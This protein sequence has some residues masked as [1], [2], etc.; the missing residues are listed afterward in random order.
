MVIELEK[1]D[2]QSAHP[3]PVYKIFFVMSLVFL[4]F[5][6]LLTILSI[7]RNSFLKENYS[8]LLSDGTFG[9]ATLSEYHP[10]IDANGKKHVYTYLVPDDSGKLNEVV[11]MV[12]P[13]IQRRLRVGDSVQIRRRTVRYLTK[14]MVLAR[15]E[16]NS[17]KISISPIPKFIGFFGIGTGLLFL[18][19]GLGARL[20]TD[21]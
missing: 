11:E 3:T 21:G 15:I 2:K 20:K 16:N 12:D 14:E 4:L 10:V 17:E 6:G 8:A 7:H 5:F 9:F 18:I 1:H 19:L 13:V